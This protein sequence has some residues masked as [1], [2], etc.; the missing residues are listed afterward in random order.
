MTV[1]PSPVSEWE[2]R[3]V[4]FDQGSKRGIRSWFARY[5]VLS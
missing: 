3:P 5:V 4:S 1:P 2:A